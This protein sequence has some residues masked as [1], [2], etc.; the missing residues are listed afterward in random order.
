MSKNKICYNLPAEM[1]PRMFSI[2]VAVLSYVDIP[3]FMHAFSILYTELYD[4]L[5]AI[6][7]FISLITCNNQSELGISGE[8]RIM[9]SVLKLPF[10][11]C[12]TIARFGGVDSSISLQNWLH[13]IFLQPQ[14]EYL[15]LKTV[16][17]ECALLCSRNKRS[18]AN[19]WY[20]TGI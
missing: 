19:M 18:A 14:W 8:G 10:F 2:Y 9:L 12:E 20:T 6:L 13:R 15:P 7:L 3:V 11:L 16:K 4:T 5:F 17:S 1:I